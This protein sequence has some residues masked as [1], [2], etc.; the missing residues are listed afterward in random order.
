MPLPDDDRLERALK[1][2]EKRDAVQC[3]MQLLVF[4]QSSI[5]GDRDL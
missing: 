4:E 5:T 3:D 2:E 1:A